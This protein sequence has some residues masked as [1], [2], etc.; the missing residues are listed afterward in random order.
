MKQIKNKF[1]EIPIERS[2]FGPVIGTHL[3]EKSLALAWL[4]DTDKA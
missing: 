3:G 4:M 2:F 1:P